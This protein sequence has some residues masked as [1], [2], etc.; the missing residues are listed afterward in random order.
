MR[1]TRGAWR[2]SSAAALPDETAIPHGRYERNTE[3][4]ENALADIMAAPTPVRAVIM[5]GA[6]KPCA[7][8]IRVGRQNGL[9]AIFLN[10]SFVGAGPLAAELGAEGDGVVVTQVVPHFDEDLPIT[11]QYREALSACEGGAAPAFGS[12]E[13]YTV[14]RMLLLA[15]DKIPGAP[16]RASITDALEALNTFD[17]GLGSPLTLSATEHQACHRVWTTV[18]RGGRVCGGELG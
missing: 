7:K 9:S 11:R 6:Y 16:D 3:A 15:M 12:L 10:V 5:V 1:A 4:I 2:P 8:F 14:A 18:L 13:G 17:L